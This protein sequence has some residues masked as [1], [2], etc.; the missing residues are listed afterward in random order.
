[1]RVME[2]GVIR[3]FAF[4]AIA[5]LSSG[6]AAAAAPS[7]ASAAPLVVSLG[8]SIAYGYGLPSRTTQSYAALYAASIHGKFVN[9]GTPGIICQDVIDHQVPQMPARASIVILNCG[10][11][12]VG[13]FDF[14]P[15]KITRA[16]A[17][18]AAELADSQK[19]FA[20]LVTKIRA[21]EP[22]A[23]IYV[24][25]LR[26]WQRI[27]GPEPAQFARDVDAW[28]AMLAATGLHVVD[29]DSD[30]RMYDDANFLPDE[31]HPNAS[32][33]KIIATKLESLQ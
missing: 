9:L 1:M 20:R 13:G 6:T 21:K 4:T 23:T 25:N 15:A 10:T 22:G 12:D 5:I 3:T 19:S 18:T 30:A 29:I 17:A 24:V 16:P 31:I 33:S 26:H 7:A 32:G 8:D 27:H 14:T 2:I 11:N 28:N